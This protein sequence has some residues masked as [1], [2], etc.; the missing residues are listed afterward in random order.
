MVLQRFSVCRVVLQ[1]PRARHARLVTDILVRMQRETCPV[2]I[3]LLSEA[4]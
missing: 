1:I 2:E 3:Q 4:N